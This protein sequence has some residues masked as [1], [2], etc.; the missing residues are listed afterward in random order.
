MWECHWNRL[1]NAPFEDIP[2]GLRLEA[3]RVRLFMEQFYKKRPLQRLAP[4]VALR[5]DYLKIR[6]NMCY[7]VIL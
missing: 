3:K 1:K 4:R 5:G 7:C 6:R 2:E